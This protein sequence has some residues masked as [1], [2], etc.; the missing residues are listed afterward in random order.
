VRATALPLYAAVLGFGFAI[1]AGPVAAQ[2]V[3]VPATLQYPLFAKILT[4]DRNLATRAGSELVIGVVYQPAFRASRV[5][6]D[7]FI[8]AVILS[9]IQTVT[10]LPV[11]VKRIVLDNSGTLS[12]TL[13]R[14]RIHAIYIAPLRATDI[15]ELVTI[16]KQLGVLSLTGVPEY[17]AAGVSVGL[18]EREGKPRILINL[19]GARAEGADFLSTLLTLAEVV[20]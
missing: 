6:A 17:V 3:K 2:Q 15:G 12:A 10:G 19:P 13:R 5:V 14:E 20:R 4:F 7:E 18:D 9:P 1:H 8:E 11:T 16:T